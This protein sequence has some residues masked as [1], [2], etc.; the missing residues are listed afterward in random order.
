MIYKMLG[1]G[2]WID[3]LQKTLRYTKPLPITAL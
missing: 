3:I 1:L 2:S